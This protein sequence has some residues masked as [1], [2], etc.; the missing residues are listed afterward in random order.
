MSRV[1]AALGL[2]VAVLAPVAARADADPAIG[3]AFGSFG[4]PYRSQLRAVK[5]GVFDGSAWQTSGPGIVQRPS[6]FSLDA[7]GFGAGIGYDGL[8]IQADVRSA[9][10]VAQGAVT[11]GYRLN[12]QFGNFELWTRFAGGPRIFIDWGTRSA[13]RDTVGGIETVA[14]A[15]IDWFFWKETMAIGLKG[16]GIPSWTF[17]AEFAVDLDLHLGLRIVL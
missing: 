5:P 14:E 3:Y 16:A 10:D 2:I 7:V 12:L 17:P 15:G 8:N 11:I 4:V 13:T 1:I 9:G 6:V